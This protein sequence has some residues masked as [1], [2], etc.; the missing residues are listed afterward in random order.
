MASSNDK[1]NIIQNI[2]G[3]G[4][5]G[6][7][8]YSAM[9]SDLIET[10]VE[11]AGKLNGLTMGGS[12]I[13]TELREVGEN[14]R[15]D[16]NAL[17]EATQRLRRETIENLK[18]KFLN[19]IESFLEDGEARTT[20]EKRA[21]FAAI[22]DSLKEE[23]IGGGRRTDIEDLVRKGYDALAEDL[24]LLTDPQK[25]D[26]TLQQKDKQTLTEFFNNTFGSNE[27]SLERFGKSYQ[28]YSANI[29]QF[30]TRS[31]KNGFGVLANQVEAE[32]FG[33]DLDSF[34][35]KGNSGYSSKQQSVINRRFQR[36]NERLG[37]NNAAISFRSYDEGGKGV[38]SL[39]ARV[40][41]SG[42]KVLNIPLFLGKDESGNVIYRATENLS[43]RYVAPLH[44]IRADSVMDVTSMTSTRFSTLKEAQKGGGLVDFTTYIFDDILDSLR[45]EDI[46]NMSQRR[47]NEITAYERNFGLD[48]P[49][50][51]MERYGI[52]RGL[53]SNNLYGNLNAS[54]RFQASNGL[55][56]GI[57]KFNRED[58]KN[59][60]KRL[61]QFY[62]GDLVGT[63]AAQTMTARYENPYN[64][65]GLA[66]LFG[67]IGLRIDDSLTV[68]DAVKTFGI[69]DRVLLNQTAREGQLFGRYEAIESLKDIDTFGRTG[70]SAVTSARSGGLLGVSRK[71]DSTVGMNLAGFFVKERAA[72]KL[73]LAEGVS[74]FG[75]RIVTS[76]SMPKTV[77]ES[78][79]ANTRL[80]D[81]LIGFGERGIKVGG[82]ITVTDRA[83]GEFTI[84]DFFKDYGDSKGRAI[85]GH[86]DADFAAI[87]RRGG[88]E[89]FTLGVSEFTKEA[90]RSRY[91]LVG[92]MNNLNLNS[93]L[94][95]YL[96]KDTTTYADQDT[97]FRKLASVTGSQAEAMALES[98]YYG[99]MG[100]RIENTLLSTTGQFKK[101]VYNSAVGMFGALSMIRNYGDPSRGISSQDYFAQQMEL[102]TQT[103]RY[104]QRINSLYNRSHTS[105]GAA[106]A[107]ERKG[108]YLYEA[109]DLVLESRRGVDDKTLGHILGTVEEFHGDYGLKDERKLFDLFK[110]HGLITDDSTASNNAFL[111]AYKSNIAFAAGYAT[112]GGVH[113]ELGRN[114]AR[115]EPRFM[116]YLYTNLRTNFG[117]TGGEA[118]EYLSS[119]ILRQAG[120]ESKANAT[121]GMHVSMMSLSSLPG[122]DFVNELRSIGDIQKM[123]QEDLLDLRG[124]GQGDERRLSEFLSRR[125]KGQI[126]DFSDIIQDQGRLDQIKQRLGGRTQIFLPGAETLENFEGFKIRGSGQTIQI[127]GEYNRYL[128]DLVSSINA[129]SVEKDDKLF[130]R[131]L[132]SFESAKK[133]LSTVVGTAVRQSLSGNVMGSGSYMGS[134]FRFGLTAE[135]G[136]EFDVDLKK[137]NQMR[138]G[139]LDAFN[140]KE[141]YV[142][143]QD[144][145]G[146]LDGMTTYKEALKKE[147]RVRGFNGEKLS[148]D[149][150]HE[151]T[152]SL[153][154][155]RMKEFF[156]SMVD[157]NYAAAT[158]TAQRNPTL[159]FQH[160]LPGVSI[161]RYDFADGNQDAMF[162]YFKQYRGSFYDEEG[163]KLYRERKHAILRKNKAAELGFS[164]FDDS[165]YLSFLDDRREIKAN[166]DRL[167]ATLYGEAIVDSE[168]KRKIEEISFYDED[169]R[170]QIAKRVER[171]A[172]TVSPEIVSGKARIDDLHQR[173]VD[174]KDKQAA[175]SEAAR[176]DDS[177]LSSV[178][179]RTSDYFSEE[180]FFNRRMQTSL[181]EGNYFDA[182]E[183]TSRTNLKALQNKV[184]SAMTRARGGY[185]TSQELKLVLQQIED[186][187]ANEVARLQQ[188]NR[189]LNDTF[190]TTEEAEKIKLKKSKSIERL[191]D[192]RGQ[193]RHVSH[194][195][196]AKNQFEIGKIKGAY[197]DKSEGR[198]VLEDADVGKLKSG[199]KRKMGPGTYLGR[200]EYGYTDPSITHLDDYGLQKRP[201]N[202]FGVERINPSRAY[203]ELYSE[204]YGGSPIDDED[205]I[206]LRKAREL[207]IIQK[208][209]QQHQMEDHLRRLNYRI[210]ATEGSL[211]SDLEELE[212]LRS[213]PESKLTE[214]QLMKKQELESAVEDG[215]RRLVS[216]GQTKTEIETK[217]PSIQ[218]AIENLVLNE[219]ESRLT[220]NRV[221]ASEAV[222][223]RYESQAIDRSTGDFREDFMMR[224]RSFYGFYDPSSGDTPLEFLSKNREK[225]KRGFFDFV[226]SEVGEG[227]TYRSLTAAMKDMLGLT[228]DFRQVE[229]TRFNKE[230]GQYETVKKSYIASEAEVERIVAEDDA[231]NKLRLERQALHDPAALEQAQENNEYYRVR[232]EMFAEQERLRLMEEA[233]SENLQIREFEKE[234]MKLDPDRRMQLTDLENE[235]IRSDLESYRISFEDIED[236]ALRDKLVEEKKVINR[237]SHIEDTLGLKRGSIDSFES[238]RNFTRGMEGV[239]FSYER[240]DP[241]VD[242][243][244]RE[245][246]TIGGE[247]DKMMTGLLTYHAKYGEHGGG[248]IRFPEINITANLTNSL[249]GATTQYDGRMDLSRFMI[250]DFDADIYQIFHDTNRTLQKRFAENS[251]SFHGF[252]QAGGEYLFN[253]HILEKGMKE[254]S[255][256]I[257]T[258]GMNAEQYILDE[259]SK[260]KILKDV[261]PIDVQVKAGMFSLIHNASEAAARNGGDFAEAMRHTRGAAALVSVA[262]EVLVIKSKKLP[263]ASNIADNFLKSLQ[264]GFSTGSGDSIINFFNE[265][266]FKGG[267]FEGGGEITVSDIEFK[268]LPDGQAKE[269]LTRALEGIRMGKAEFEQTMHEMARSGHKLNI[270]QMMSDKRAA[271][272]VRDS[273][274]TTTRQLRQLMAVSME[275][276]LINTETGSF[277]YDVLERGLA[278]IQSDMGNAF[279]AGSRAK[280]LTGLA[281]G[282]LGASYLVGS[283]VST[284]KLDIEE[285]FSDMRVKGME[286]NFSRIQNVD[287]Q[288]NPGGITGMGQN[289]S[290]YKRP[291]NVGESYVT[292]SYA[293]RMYGESPTY[294]EAQAAARQFTSVGGQAFL[295]VQDNRRPISNSYIT[296]SLRD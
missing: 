156:F 153:T 254:F 130:D 268:D 217:L 76:T 228:Q 216:L 296:K 219:H 126:L 259:Y 147:L 60:I 70:L 249:T 48:G 65:N 265:H 286:N 169:G 289:E 264:T 269:A 150:I 58:Q 290:F 83:A 106:T 133:Y 280:G 132:K 241:G 183:R 229:L 66:R 191:R 73:G 248:I 294:G 282:V 267:V 205:M 14:L 67:Q 220:I 57:E 177:A 207:N 139:I 114:L 197:V 137:R 257:G 181:V 221:I 46:L 202:F 87:K 218:D 119:I 196:T 11:N 246:T 165:K 56:T 291:I 295:A 3:G 118:T 52:N 276:G 68:F 240:Y 194:V 180:E 127:E 43:S 234:Q 138:S 50:T 283:T 26:L 64:P 53:I 92:Q 204:M 232:Q 270:L 105:L 59:V 255:A 19:Q 189:E 49:R 116:N 35:K 251:A 206:E 211:Y 6:L 108:A 209:S 15:V 287:R 210:A 186:N 2:A 91:H 40:E 292:N 109:V 131:S 175:A 154:G 149:R 223:N 20:G 258:A 7:L 215:Q 166:I 34:F 273:N 89:G 208:A 25:A 128:T 112:T 74:Y 55:V 263:V 100:G 172:S 174:L 146:F 233:N 10:A 176:G 129:L 17:D 162:K 94:F 238:L 42:N 148:E 99:S 72:A 252:Y 281:L 85:I 115:V 123:S 101:G 242:G 167:K 192:L 161:M 27:E 31:R 110:K 33:G 77:V 9:K 178:R 29:E 261:G 136:F 212:D 250:G 170:V 93:K 203:E 95:S 121:L 271:K 63:S 151:M 260:E 226:E 103:D 236:Q 39:Y 155:G 13:K 135:Q 193:S 69:K 188:Y 97:I 198:I 125:G 80:L 124:F 274:L 231:L 245:Q 120:V 37:N 244:V 61:L 81:D 145:Q 285:K 284:N 214:E 54:R 152:R 143:F 134:G 44:V 51:M 21:F 160:N 168:G 266:V 96:V 144:A 293:G 279:S 158:A 195:I 1:K 277:N 41:F 288:A 71:A 24:T 142:L 47:I 122:E 159:S 239:E 117:L 28:K 98:L 225:A 199:K 88:M 272:A 163:A 173:R 157:P 16:V 8:G 45:T 200:I 82:G 275:G 185:Q 235:G 102:R 179:G 4:I 213:L 262:Q 12:A 23:E 237:L 171:D 79:I 78:G 182:M 62:E 187:I 222:L 36:L 141:G 111:Q 184:D 230:T 90:G 32:S 86:L 247:V 107:Q 201:F 256:R 5:L 18:D 75:G 190:L 224:A 38:R 227:K 140:R 253:M 113:A 22:F 30:A 164:S 104:L 243:L 278:R 84:E